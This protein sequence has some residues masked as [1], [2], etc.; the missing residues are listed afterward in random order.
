MFSGWRWRFN[1]VRAWKR[2]S[3]GCEWLIIILAAGK[4]VGGHCASF[5]LPIFQRAEETSAALDVCVAE[6]G[7]VQLLIPMAAAA[8]SFSPDVEAAQSSADTN[9]LVPE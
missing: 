8:H 9:I 2:Q 7:A 4:T 1:D 5:C 6:G 3:K